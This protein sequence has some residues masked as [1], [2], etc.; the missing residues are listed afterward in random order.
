MH[1]GGVE[2]LIDDALLIEARLRLHKDGND[3]TRTQPE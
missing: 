2:A 1:Q 3:A